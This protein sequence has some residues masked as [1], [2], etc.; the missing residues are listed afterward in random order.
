MDSKNVS[1]LKTRF[2]PYRLKDWELKFEKWKFE[3]KTVVDNYNKER[4][5]IPVED[6]NDP[7]QTEISSEAKESSNTTKLKASQLPIDFKH[8]LSLDANT[9]MMTYV[10]EK[11]QHY[12]DKLDNT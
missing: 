11:S 3:L 12:A 9:D 1:L 2:F 5:W 4:G 8:L 7:K 10:Q 6:P